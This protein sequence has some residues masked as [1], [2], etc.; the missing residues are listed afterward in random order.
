M[1][2]PS[3]MAIAA[4]TVMLWIMWSDTIRAKRPS[5]VLY[6]VRIALFLIISG[7]L[8][9]NLFRYP[10]FFSGSARGVV[11]VAV[12]VGVCGAGYFAR[13]LVLRR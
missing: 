9:V 2:S 4:I 7:I 6:T 12:L 5:Q 11:I 8:A 13:R 3:G 1:I 10:A